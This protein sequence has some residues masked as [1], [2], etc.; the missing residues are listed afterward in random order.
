MGRVSWVAG[1][2]SAG[3]TAL[4]RVTQT[5]GGLT[6]AIPVAGSRVS[7]DQARRPLGS[8]VR[9]ME[10]QIV[11]NPRDTL[12]CPSKEA[13]ETAD[14]V[15]FIEGGLGLTEWIR[16]T[17]TIASRTGAK[18]EVLNYALAFDIS[19]TSSFNPIFSRT[20]EVGVSPDLAPENADARRVG[21][22]IAVTVLPD[23][24][25]GRA[26]NRSRLEAAERHL[27]RLKPT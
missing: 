25:R 19:L 4:V 20:S 15:R 23:G 1:P 8:A 7:L 22:R 17:T 5:G 3:E 21:H 24:A 9:E 16:E 26:T 11:H 13:P 18:P 14:G 2:E 12:A 27:A 6:L 10:V